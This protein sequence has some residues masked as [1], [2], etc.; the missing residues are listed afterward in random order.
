MGALHGWEV[1]G[2]MQIDIIY[3]MNARLSTACCSTFD[4]EHWPQ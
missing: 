1:I 3:R 4:A 2:E